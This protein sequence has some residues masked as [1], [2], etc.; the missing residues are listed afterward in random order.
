MCGESMN[1]LKVCGKMLSKVRLEKIGIHQAMKGQFTIKY[2][3][4]KEI[5]KIP[6][7]FPKFPVFSLSG[8]FDNQIPCFPCAVATLFMYSAIWVGWHQVVGCYQ[9]LSD[10]SGKNIY[11]FKNEQCNR[12]FHT[13]IYLWVIKYVVSSWTKI[14]WFLHELN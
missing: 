6:C 12:L 1:M 11:H 8:K 13:H 7:V 2:L 9:V 4:F 3:I 5:C 10:G 14:I